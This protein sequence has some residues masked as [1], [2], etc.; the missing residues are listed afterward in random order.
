[1]YC[2]LQNLSGGE[3]EQ[4]YC[5]TVQS[6][7]PLRYMVLKAWFLVVQAAFATA[8]GEILSDKYSSYS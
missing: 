8:R 4:H 3:N 5:I 6:L 7:D 1:M 2:P